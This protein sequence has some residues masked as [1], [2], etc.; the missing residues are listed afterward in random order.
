MPG[1]T[2]LIAFSEGAKMILILLPAYGRKYETQGD[3]FEAWQSGVDFKIEGGPYCSIRDIDLIRKNY[4][5]ISIRFGKG[6]YCQ[7]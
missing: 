6:L 7:V 5:V 3:C 2:L 1:L 4:S